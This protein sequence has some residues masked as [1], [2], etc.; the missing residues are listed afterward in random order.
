MRLPDYENGESA[1]S[2]ACRDL[3]ALLDA[4]E[5]DP[6]SFYLYTG[7]ARGLWKHRRWL[8]TADLFRGRRQR[9]FIWAT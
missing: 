6:R 8:L 7:R 4:Y 5:K 9:R 1:Q 2:A 3:T